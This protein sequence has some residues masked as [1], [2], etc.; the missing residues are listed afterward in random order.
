MTRFGISIGKRWYR[1][2]NFKI[3]ENLENILK[4]M[5]DIIDP[6][7]Y[8]LVEKD[9]DYYEF[10]LKPEIFNENIYDLI[11]EISPLT[12]PNDLEYEMKENHIDICSKE[13]IESHHF[14]MKVNEEGKYFFERDDH[15]VGEEYPF[16]PLYWITKEQKFSDNIAIRAAVINLWFDLNKYSGEDETEMLRII[17]NM[18]AKYYSNPL[19]KAFI[20]YVSG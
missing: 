18:K 10:A 12:C 8:E 1:D 4:D 13:F 16:Y 5:S 19:S 17:N 3:E 6:S 2:K 15:E 9:E 7:M 14:K 11:L 20:Y